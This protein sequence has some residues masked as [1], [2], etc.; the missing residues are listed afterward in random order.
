MSTGGNAAI[1]L[2]AKDS[3]GT[4][5]NDKANELFFS[6]KN[7]NTS[8]LDST[9]TYN[10]Y[11][12]HH[13]LGHRLFF[14]IQNSAHIL[15]D[16]VKLSGKNLGEINAIDY[17]A[18]LGT[19]FMLGGLLG[20]KRFDYNDHLP[21]WQSTAK[22]VCMQAGIS[23][24]D[25]VT[26]DIN[27]VAAFAASKN[28]QYDIVVSRNVIE[29]IY[30]LPE[31]YSV[32]FRHNAKAVVY[33]T[34][35]ANYHNPA[36]R[37]YH[38]YIHK[39]VEKQYYKQQRV[40]E[41]KKLQPLLSPGKVAELTELTRGKG[42]QDFID[43]VN[44]FT[45]NKPI[46]ADSTLRSNVCDCINGVWSEHLLTKNEYGNIIQTAGFKMLY[47]AGYWDTHYSSS[48]KN[49]LVSIFNK[50]IEILGNKR[51]VILSPFVNVVAYN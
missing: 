43:A 8:A 3:L 25:Y 23:I 49:S 16:A 46:P 42:Q 41:I 29:H 32:I 51:G 48:L 33:S 10:D 4:L 26:G 22:A 37:L 30:S 21:E 40:E 20:F 38:I 19:L 47:T 6:L 15:Y 11:F 27:A 36:M 18:G 13:H 1:F 39:K 9:D 7:F 34:T 2:A 44:N 35:T 31:F 5:I 12:I 14:S 17:G 24:T 45:N 50:T 28:I